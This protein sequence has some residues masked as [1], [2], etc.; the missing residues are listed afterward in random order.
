MLAK[1]ENYQDECSILHTST[2]L[3]S[4][5]RDK[6]IRSLFTGFLPRTLWI[7][8]GVVVFFGAYQ[9]AVGLCSKFG[10]L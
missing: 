6:G 9:A 10:V 4:I 3:I 7:T 1:K 5:Y 2:M 8:L